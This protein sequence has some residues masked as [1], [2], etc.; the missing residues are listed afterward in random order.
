M[1]LLPFR[2]YFGVLM[3]P[4]EN[5]MQ[6][7]DDEGGGGVPGPPGPFLFSLDWS[8]NKT[9]DSMYAALIL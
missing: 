7:T 6:A 5:L 9:R 3:E 2:S 1:D 4:Q 8:R